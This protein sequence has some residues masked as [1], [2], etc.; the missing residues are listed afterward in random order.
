MNVRI[1]SL[2]PETDSI[3][4]TSSSEYYRKANVS[5]LVQVLL[6]LKLLGLFGLYDNIMWNSF[7]GV[8][9]LSYCHIYVDMFIDWN[10]VIQFVNMVVVLK[11]RFFFKYASLHVIRHFRI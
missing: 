9:N 8:M 11:Y 6:M 4:L 3:I 10:V 7:H 1:I 2:I 5:L